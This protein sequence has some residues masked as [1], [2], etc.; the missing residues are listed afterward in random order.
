MSET[1]QGE[2]DRLERLL[3]ETIA[4]A[5]PP[6]SKVGNLSVSINAGGTG[7]WIAVTCCLVSF[8]VNVCLAVAFVNHDR[9]IDDLGHYLNAV[10]MAAPGLKPEDYQVGDADNHY[11]TPSSTAPD[12]SG[13]GTDQPAAD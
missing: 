12:R 7:V 9:K 11:P 2:L 1:L 4:L 10:Y 13:N 6:S 8:V 5:S 3:L